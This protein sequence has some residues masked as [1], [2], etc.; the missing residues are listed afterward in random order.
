MNNKA[1]K[2]VL[3]L[4]CLTASLAALSACGKKTTK[5]IT[6]EKPA[7]TNKQTTNKQTTKEKITKVVT[8][9]PVVF[10]IVDGEIYEQI[11]Y[12]PNTA[13]IK[14]PNIP[15]KE[16]YQISK[17]SDYNLTG[18]D[19][20][21]FAMYFKANTK[22]TVEYYLQNLDNDEYTLNIEDTQTFT[23]TPD[24]VIK[25]NIKTYEGFS[26]I[27]NDV[28]LNIVEDE[29]KNTIKV[30]Y[31]RIKYDINIDLDNGSDVINYS[32]K[33][34]ATIPTIATPT[35][36]GYEFIKFTSNNKD[37][38][39]TIPVS[40]DLDIKANYNAKTNTK[41]TIKYYQENLDDDDF[42]ELESYRET[43]TGTTDTL[44]NVNLNNDLF[45]GFELDMDKTISSGNINGDESLV[46]EL[47][48]KR[49]RFNVTYKYADGVTVDKVETLKYEAHATEINVD[50]DGYTFNGWMYNNSYYNFNDPI[51]SD[52]TLFASYEANSGIAYKV[53][54]YIKDFDGEY[55][56]DDYISES[57]YTGDEKYADL[58]EYDYYGY[59]L[60]NELSNTKGNIL[61]DGS[62]ELNLY[63]DRL[64]YTFIFV[65][66]VT[67]E[68]ITTKEAL[69]EQTFD[70]Q[71][72]IEKEGYKLRST[73]FYK[74]N[75]GEISGH[76]T[77]YN[78]PEDQLPYIFETLYSNYGVTEYI[79]KVQYTEKTDTKYTVKVYYENIIDDDFT[80]FETVELSGKTNS[81][82]TPE[83]I[84]HFTFYTARGETE[85]DE[86]IIKPDGS[87][88]IRAYYK[89]NKYDV[90]IVS[91]TDEQENINYLK[92]KYGAK[93]NEPAF[94]KL[95][96][97]LDYYYDQYGNEFSFDNIIDQDLTIY[98]NWVAIENQLTVNV[99]YQ[100]TEYDEDNDYELISSTIYNNILTNQ[101]I[102]V[103]DY[104]S[105]I[106]GLYFYNY[107]TNSHT[108]L[109]DGS[110]CLNIYYNR[111]TYDIFFDVNGADFSIEPLYSVRYGYIL[112]NPNLTKVGYTLDKWINVIYDDEGEREEDFDFNN[113]IVSSNLNLN[114]LWIANTDTPYTVC[115]YLENLDGDYEPNETVYYGTTDTDLDLDEFKEDYEGYEYSYTEA[116]YSHIRGNE[117]TYIS[118]Y[119]NR[120]R[121][122][123]SFECN[124]ADFSLNN[125]EAKH[126]STL[127][128]PN[129][130]K[131][132]YTL[133]KWIDNNNDGAEYVFGNVVEKELSLEAIWEANTDTAY[134]VRYH[135][136]K[137]EGDY[138]ITEETHY[139]TTDTII[140]IDALKKEFT[141]YNYN[142]N[143]ISYNY[144]TI[145]GNGET[146]IDLY[147]SRKTF[148]LNIYCDDQ[149]NYEIHDYTGNNRYGEE[150]NISAYLIGN[151]GYLF[152]GIY[153]DSEYNDLI[154]NDTKYSFNITE[155][156]D[157]YIKA[158]EIDDLALFTFTSDTENII[159][160]GLKDGVTEP[161]I[162]IPLV[163]TGIGSSAFYNNQSIKNIFISKNV[164]F[165]DSTAFAYCTLESVEF[166]PECNIEYLG[167]SAF[168]DSKIDEIIFC[169]NIK[170]FG[171]NLFASA[172]IKNFTLPKNIEIIGDNAIQASWS[173]YVYGNELYINTLIIPKSVKKIG[174]SAFNN[175]RIDNLVFED[176]IN[177]EE[178]G[179][180]IFANCKIQRITL[181]NNIE[182]I[183]DQLFVSSMYMGTVVIPKNIKTIGKSAFKSADVAQIIF[184]NGSLLERIDDEAFESNGNL[185]GMLVLPDNLLTI[186]KNAFSYCDINV[187]KLN[188]SL[189]SIDEEAFL[190]NSNL[191]TIFN[192][193]ALILQAGSTDYGYVAYYV[194]D[195]AN[196]LNNEYAQNIIIEGN[197]T[198]YVEFTDGVET[199]RVLLSYTGDEKVIN[200]I[201]PK[202]TIISD[203]VFKNKNMYDVIIPDNVIEIGEYAFQNCKYLS[204][205]TLGPNVETIGNLAFDDCFRLVEIYNKS[206]HISLEYGEDSNGQIAYNAK[207]IHEGNGYSSNVYL[208]DKFIIFN[209]NSDYYLLGIYAD[210]SYS[211]LIIPDY[212]TIIYNYAFKNMKSI[213]TIDMQSSSVRIIESSSFENL[214]YVSYLALP[215]T[216]EEIKDNAFAGLGSY[217]ENGVSYFNIDE[218][219]NLKKIGQYAFNSLNY[220]GDLVLPDSLEVLE[221]NAFQSSSI[222]SVTIG[223]KIEVLQ[224]FAYCERLENVYYSSEN[225]VKEITKDAFNNCCLLKQFS[226]GSKVELIEN[227]A[228][229]YCYKLYVIQNK[230]ELEIIKGSEENGNI[231]LYAYVVYDTEMP[232]EYY[233]DSNFVYYVDGDD[234]ILV[235]YI[236]ETSDTEIITVEIP[237]NVTIIGHSAFYHLTNLT[238]SLTEN[239]SIKKIEK[240]AFYNCNALNIDLREMPNLTEIDDHAFAYDSFDT[241]YISKDITYLGEYAFAGARA[242]I[243]I[244]DI[245]TQLDT[246]TEGLLHQANYDALFIPSQIIKIEDNN[247]YYDWHTPSYIFYYGNA[248]ELEDLIINENNPGLINLFENNLYFYSESEEEGNYFTFDDEGF[249]TTYDKYKA[250]L[251]LNRIVELMKNY[252]EIAYN[253]PESEYITEY[254]YTGVYHNDDKL[255]LDTQ[256]LYQILLNE[257]SS[258]IDLFSTFNGPLE[259]SYDGLNFKAESAYYYASIDSYEI[260]IN[261]TETDFTL[262][263]NRL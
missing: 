108:I 35:K 176:G 236:G 222:K 143:S 247:D 187:I 68:L 228:F 78:S 58:R 109:P 79:I 184:E 200:T 81:Q 170:E 19:V 234:L 132:G 165:V 74:S 21:V 25:P 196:I 112:D 89:R 92:I 204:R 145:K 179:E 152:D 127:E 136:E 93:L 20:Y 149:T 3:F 253:N 31:D 260:V 133:V 213:N 215:E 50:R 37:I 229:E 13:S 141:E 126:G 153:A 216:L 220:N 83:E 122:E 15:S 147:Y 202:T 42:V 71:S 111:H 14:E 34:G 248:T 249:P 157:I 235:D 155:N 90:E 183:Y 43:Q 1:K 198:Y 59:T 156:T 190:S 169:D 62:L 123:V 219:I 53:N 185:D 8:N 256:G 30:Y 177:L 60:N 121:Y 225:N 207:R 75:N 139:G 195:S 115:V 98:T 138:E 77:S 159:I 69:F 171:A 217:A 49:K 189:A 206:S 242:L 114:A 140:D 10:F 232:E 26:C 103:N 197:Y 158:K 192:N 146:Y 218:C 29:T 162:V 129:L 261:K 38:D 55:V 168:S 105:D 87:T 22:Y 67:E 203:G 193:S 208:D 134:T 173:N 118:L 255:Q 251:K 214:N 239:N 226:V 182:K 18:E 259:L 210:N 209:Y 119:Y 252:L 52:I 230:S 76:I 223:S 23:T 6:T 96:Y 131:A 224:S 188:S 243:I 124:D 181:P 163:A 245:D 148:I 212:V 104:K 257:E 28:E 142:P 4:L 11:E 45:T 164:K 82:I 57:G 250:L 221:K 86:L 233:S 72:V 80:L 107:D 128:D 100:K 227:G 240:Y 16:G 191:T 40:K 244:F 94:T 150:I 161:N 24:Q 12:T 205:I 7:T 101:S 237:D 61:A 9:N 41:Y 238:I 262:S 151:L 66:S 178:L 130:T 17:W 54:Y 144:N 201:N 2:P 51:Y 166:D 73:S 125:I 106:E 258:D 56:L 85:D 120:V 36:L 102:N 180:E 32:L 44:A 48:Y 241:I 175:T 174:K 46:L 117:D 70:M 154:T 246:I 27:N 95:G 186:G 33:Y 211:D 199:N 5:K 97:A 137:I 167:N 47:F 263:K 63:Y 64:T 194:T 231:A 39:L 91:N 99:Y 254:L 65:D 113:H 135:L 116:Q 88:V 160:T 110:S 84:E 172:Q